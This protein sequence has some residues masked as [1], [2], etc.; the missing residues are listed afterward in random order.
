[1]FSLWRIVLAFS[2]LSL[3]TVKIKL[4]FTEMVLSHIHSRVQHG[5]PKMLFECKITFWVDFI[6]S[7]LMDVKLFNKVHVFFRE[8]YNVQNR[9]NFASW[10]A[11]ILYTLGKFGRVITSFKR[12]E[13]SFKSCGEKLRPFCPVY[14]LL[15]I[16]DKSIGINHCRF[17]FINFFCTT[18][19]RSAMTYK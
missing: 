9:F 1:M 13:I 6:G 12:M 16:L 3:P 15:R 7:P 2:C 8:L 4:Q 10:M 11:F 14:F 19:S 18:A 5:L 17:V